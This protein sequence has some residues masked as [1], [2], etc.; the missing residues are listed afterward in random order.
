MAWYLMPM[1][2]IDQT[3]LNALKSIDGDGSMDT[4]QVL[5]RLYLPSLK[6]KIEELKTHARSGNADEIRYIAT[7]LRSNSQML[8][9]TFIAEVAEQIEYGG[10]VEHHIQMLEDIYPRI[11]EALRE[12]V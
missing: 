7:A 2:L 10:P 5:L 6:E 11:L 9:I 8:G 4:L 12:Y 3:R 1:K